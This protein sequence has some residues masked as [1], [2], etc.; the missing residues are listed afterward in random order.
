MEQRKKVNDLAGDLRLFAATH[1]QA[2]GHVLGYRHVRPQRIGL[3]HHGRVALFGRQGGD[4]AAGQT[5]AAGDRPDEPRYRPKQGRLAA[6]GTAE[7]GDEA[8]VLHR[9]SHRLQ[10]FLGA[11]ANRQAF[12]GKI[13]GHTHAAEYRSTLRGTLAA[14]RD[15]NIAAGGGAGTGCKLRVLAVLALMGHLSCRQSRRIPMRAIGYQ[16]LLPIDDPASL[17]DITLPNPEPGARDLL[18]EVR[19]VSVNPVDTKVRRRA[20]PEAGAW[21]VLG[22]DAAGTVAAAGSQ[23]TL[24]KPGDA[25]FYSGALGRQGT[26]AEFHVVDERLVGRMPHSLNWSQAAA[27]PLTAVTAWEALFDRLD[28]KKPVPGAARAILIVGGA[29]GV[30][31]IAIPARP[32]AHRPDGD[33]HGLAPGDPGMGPRT[34]GPPCRRPLPAAG[35][36]GGGPRSRRA[37][38]RLLDHEYRPAPC[39]NRRTD[40]SPGPLRADRRPGHDGRQPLQAQRACPC[41]GSSCSRVRCS[42][43]PTSEP[44][45]SFLNEVSRLVDAGDVAHDPGREFRPDQRGKPQARPCLDRERPGA[46]ARSSSKGSP[47]RH[48][49]H[50]GRA[51]AQDVV[52]GDHPAGAEIAQPG[53]VCHALRRRQRTPAGIGAAG[54]PVELA[55]RLA[56]LDAG[57]DPRI[58]GSGLGIADISL[59]V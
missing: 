26:N 45:A 59:R 55:W 36:S 56:D 27:L 51:A 13:T 53:I 12:D 25:V 35:G 34:R 7:K 29:G 1:A 52:A 19:A 43:R 44:R 6:A 42:R 16:N 47:G 38:G 28:V 31:S 50:R 57:L 23:A 41:I 11:V 20:K 10:H 18:V 30:G 14:K 48:R 37:R 17:V 4:V 49:K 2:V 22:W 58:V 24:F 5:N 9:Q 39:R 46:G 21:K 15:T 33:R 8:A 3:E 40:R 32:P 54:R